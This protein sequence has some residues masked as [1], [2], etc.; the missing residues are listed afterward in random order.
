MTISTLTVVPEVH[1][2]GTAPC[3]EP[4]LSTVRSVRRILSTLDDSPRLGEYVSVDLLHGL[5][6]VVDAAVDVIEINQSLGQRELVMTDPSVCPGGQLSWRDAPGKRPSAHRYYRC[7]E[8]TRTTP[9]VESKAQLVQSRFQERGHLIVGA[10]VRS[11]R[12]HPEGS[13]I[14][15]CDEC[16]TGGT[17]NPGGAQVADAPQG[18]R[19]AQLHRGF[20]LA[21]EAIMADQSSGASSFLPWSPSRRRGWGV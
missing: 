20:S 5:V 1:P 13:A 18:S 2:S 3:A 6:P 7:G 11:G 21:H 19:V 12:Q 4:L 15:S 9:G 17:D 8:S 16:I 14:Q 10:C